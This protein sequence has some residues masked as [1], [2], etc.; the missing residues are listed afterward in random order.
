MMLIRICYPKCSMWYNLSEKHLHLLFMCLYRMGTYRG[1]AAFQSVLVC[2]VHIDNG[3]EE[4]HEID[5]L[6]WNN[7]SKVPWL[8]YFPAMSNATLCKL[9]F[10]LLSQN[11]PTS[12]D[13]ASFLV[14]LSGSQCNHSHREILPVCFLFI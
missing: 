4:R 10:V 11:G 5:S 14:V 2:M 6:G 7:A 13:G 1:N 9:C 3:I 12:F 8:P